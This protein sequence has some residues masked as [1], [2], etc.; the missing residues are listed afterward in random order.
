MPQ[1]IFDAF[2][3]QRPGRLTQWTISETPLG[4]ALELP[5][6]FAA[7]PVLAGEG[8]YRHSDSAFVVQW[9]PEAGV[10]A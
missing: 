1:T 10:S 4:A 8:G 3:H 2:V 6:V 9:E 7:S 5:P